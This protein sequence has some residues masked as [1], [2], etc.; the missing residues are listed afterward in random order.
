MIYKIDMQFYEI[1]VTKIIKLD[2]QE[3]EL[4]FQHNTRFDFITVE[5]YLANEMIHSTRL[6]YGQNIFEHCFKVITP[7]I[8][9]TEDDLSND[10]FSSV[11]V[12]KDTFGTSVFLFFQSNE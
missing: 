4:K 6:N 9:M 12:N 7:I 1:P 3:Y 8:P 10:S 11:P 5:V 2:N